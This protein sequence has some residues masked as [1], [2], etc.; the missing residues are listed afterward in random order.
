MSSAEPPLKAERILTH[1]SDGGDKSFIQQNLN[2]SRERRVT[3]RGRGIGRLRGR[4][5]SGKSSIGRQSRNET[6]KCS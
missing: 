1:G 6:N 2:L 5:G 4:L 3:A